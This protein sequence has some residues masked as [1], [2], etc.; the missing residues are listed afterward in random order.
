MTLLPRGQANG[1][2]SCCWM[3]V[4]SAVRLDLRV[5]VNPGAPNLVNEAALPVHAYQ[6]CA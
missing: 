6:P 3:N 2:W 5:D 4:A 1:I